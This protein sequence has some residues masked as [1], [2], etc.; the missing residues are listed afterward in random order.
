MR[1]RLTVIMR[2]IAIAMTMA[3]GAC[4]DNATEF[5]G[6]SDPVDFNAVVAPTSNVVSRTIISD[7]NYPDNQ[8]FVAYASWLDEGKNWDSDKAEAKVFINGDKVA[9]NT[10]LTDKWTTETAYY[11]PDI[12]SLTFAAYSPCIETLSSKFSY[13]HT[14]GNLTISD[15]DVANEKD[16]D[17]MVADVQKN[18]T[19]EIAASGVPVAFRHKLALVAF[20][21]GLIQDYI[22][23]GTTYHLYLQKVELRKVKT[24]GNYSSASNLWSEQYEEETVVIY[25]N[26]TPSDYSKGYDVT[27]DISQHISKPILVMPQVHLEA[28]D[29]SQT[30][31]YIKWYDSK[32]GTTDDRSVNIRKKITD[33]HWAINSSYTYLLLWE[34]GTP[35]Y[36]E[37]TTPEVGAW[38]NGGNYTITID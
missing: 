13:D 29:L 6:Q 20:N 23:G 15:W 19:S 35:T 14:T 36:I 38:D 18:L 27:T 17:L 34:R 12:G 24:K 37:F 7:L 26:P 11:W 1:S 30:H 3:L 21:A 33:S 25:E 31:I 2:G 8:P 22:E 4:V 5:L 16:V 28:D 32:T 9:F 10:Y